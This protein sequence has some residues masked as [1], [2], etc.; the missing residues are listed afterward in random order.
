M[1]IL[2]WFWFLLFC[3]HFDWKFLLLPLNLRPTLCS[4][5]VLCFIWISFVGSSIVPST[6]SKLSPWNFHPYLRY[7]LTMALCLK[8]TNPHSNLTPSPKGQICI[9]SLSHCYFRV[10]A[11]SHQPHCSWCKLGFFEH[12]RWGLG[13][14]M[15]A[16]DPWPWSHQRS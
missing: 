11:G 4:S 12:S 6:T 7:S 3:H 10:D 13:S 2:I 16:V 14:R 9:H 15:G 8:T 1:F 5:L